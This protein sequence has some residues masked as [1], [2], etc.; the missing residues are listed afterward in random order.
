MKKVSTVA[1][2]PLLYCTVYNA[3]DGGR[4]AGTHSLTP[5]I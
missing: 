1:A 5:R 2:T 4:N 3:P